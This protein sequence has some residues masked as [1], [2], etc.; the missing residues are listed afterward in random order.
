MDRPVVLVVGSANMDLVFETDALPRPGQT[1]LGGRY[2]T[3]PGGKGA[4]QAVAIGRLGGAVAFCG[5]VGRDAFGESLRSSLAEAGVDLRFLRSDDEPT[6]AAGIFVDAEGRNSIV[7]APGAN[8]SLTPEDVREATTALRPSVVL[9]QLEVPLAAVA[10]AS[11]AATFVLNPAPARDLPDAVLERCAVL[12]PNETELASLTGIV[13]A[14]DEAIRR[15]VGSLL[16]RGVR[17]VVVT[18]GERGSYWRSASAEGW[19]AASK[20]AVVDT[21]A[22][23]D[24]FNG[25]LALFL[26]EGHELAEAIPLANGVGALATT[27]RGAQDAM[28]S[29]EELRAL[30][31]EF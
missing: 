18:L 9:A 28:P 6:G 30:A 20:V 13:L 29:R 7:V 21:T 15:A 31:G 22:A 23:G 2:A 26:A 24:A 25:A 12:T 17:N 11:R 27:R 16:D 3:H 14:D 1:V 10:E 8:A 5:R 4:N 19:F